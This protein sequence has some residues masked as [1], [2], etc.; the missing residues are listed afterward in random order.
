MSTADVHRVLLVEDN[1]LDARTMRRML[2][3]ADTDYDVEHVTDLESACAA[4]PG[5]FAAILLDLSLPDASGLASIAKLGEVAP[6]VPVVVLTG[7]DDPRTA[8]AAVERGAQDYLTKQAVDVETVDR[9][10][11][12][13]VA[14]RHGDLQLQSAQELLQLMHDRE[15]IARDLHD[16][17]IQ[18]LFATGMSL[19]ALLPRIV[20]PVIRDRLS[21]SVDDIDTAISS[22]RRTIFELHGGDSSNQTPSELVL[23]TVVG[24]AAALG[25]T[26]TLRIDHRIDARARHVAQE[27]AAV[28]GEALTNVARHASASAAQVEVRA[29]DDR[30]EVIVT[31]NGIGPGG[32]DTSGRTDG[33]GNGLRNLASRA[34]DADGSFHIGPGQGGGTRIEWSQPLR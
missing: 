1:P 13:A 28:V 2:E 23:R 24:A 6:D 10:V 7:L 16:S 14:R 21:M 25:F 30:V 20:D 33:S 5:D 15:R 22:L 29:D 11:R 3:R 18:Q 32:I 34:E 27:L 8:Q 31:D 19:Q 9:A 26:P 17:V 4:L 12:Y